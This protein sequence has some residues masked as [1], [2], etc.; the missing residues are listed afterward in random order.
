MFEMPIHFRSP[1]LMSPDDTVL[2][3]VDMQTKLVDAVGDAQRLIWNC[4]RLLEGAKALGIPAMATEQYPVALGPTVSVLADRLGPIAAKREFSCLDCREF[5]MR[6]VA[7]NRGKVLLAG[8]ESHVCVQQT[9]LDLLAGGFRVYLAVD[10]VGSR[11]QLDS[12]T[13]IRRMESVGC[14]LTTT[15]SA[16]FEWCRTSDRPE[17]K[18]ISALVKQPP[19]A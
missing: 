17:F 16:L 13:A 8:I 2:V 1:E 14:T 10:A 9:A 3:V 6:F 4:G 12:E 19:P 5:Q 7:N 11:A 15:E 18:A